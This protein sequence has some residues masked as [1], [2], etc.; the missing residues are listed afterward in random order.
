VQAVN[1]SD[2]AVVDTL[3]DNAQAAAQQFRQYS[4]RQVKRIVDA[5]GNAAIEKAEFY[6]EW[7]VRETGKGR[8]EDKIFKNVFPAETLMQ[9]DPQD[10]V[11]YKV[12]TEKKMVCFPKP[13][14]VVMT[15][16]PVTNPV[17][18]V[19]FKALITL[20]TRNAVVLSPHPAARECSTHATR[21][22]MDAAL[23]AG[24]PRHAIQVVEE[25][26][27]ELV[28]ALMGD[29][30]TSVILATGGPA[31]VRAAYSSGNPAMG[32]GPGNV[33][34]YVD[35]TADIAKTAKRIVRSLGFDNGMPCTTESVAIADKPIADALITEMTQAGAYM[36]CDASERKKLRICTPKADSIR[37]SLAR[38]HHGSQH[39]PVSRRLQAPAY[40]SSRS[41]AS[42][43][44]NRSA[45]KNS[46]LYSASFGSTVPT[47]ESASRW[48]CWS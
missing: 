37:K 33:P 23:N 15:L 18:T 5:V 38:I 31:M 20:L 30:R 10:Y 27:V 40:W 41:I 7:A 19:N 1:D 26:S 28:N 24:A 43:H 29:I 36:V 2:Q 3:L 22:L 6:A 21:Y 16:I 13:A 34:A 9:E 11:C 39:V 14:G 48:R 32:V 12:D 17:T 44:T 4:A 8:I 47:R 46:V 25:P 35:S 45:K 42:A